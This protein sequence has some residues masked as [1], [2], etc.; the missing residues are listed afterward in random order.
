MSYP[1]F[2]ISPEML[3]IHWPFCAAK[4]NYCDFVA[5]QDH[6]NFALQY[7]QALCNEIASVVASRPWMRGAAIKTIFLGGGTP[8]L[9]PLPLLQELFV[10]NR[11][12]V[13]VQKRYQERYCA[14]SFA[15]LIVS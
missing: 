14:G 12:R 7:H 8:S 6:H 1:F 13:Q 10:L 9:Y 15:Q 2:K 4:C 5:M 11:V 3:Y